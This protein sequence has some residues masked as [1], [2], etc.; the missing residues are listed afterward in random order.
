DPANMKRFLSAYLVEVEPGDDA[1]AQAIF[2]DEW[3]KEASQIATTLAADPVGA[4][5]VK[6]GELHN[7]SAQDV[8]L[9]LKNIGSPN[10]APFAA[11]AHTMVKLFHN[12]R[13][14]LHVPDQPPDKP[15]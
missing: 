14:A 12:M 2:D 1:K 7:I 13:A 10:S 9:D 11:L 8:R 3:N 5:N 6:P 15:P 4:K